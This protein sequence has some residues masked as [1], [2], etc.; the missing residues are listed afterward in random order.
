MTPEQQLIERYKE[1]IIKG[2]YPKAYYKNK[3]A[4]LTETLVKIREL[5]KLVN[6][7]L[8]EEL[9]YKPGE[10]YDFELCSDYGLKDD[11]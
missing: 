6:R 7:Q 9:L 5:E 2:E 3:E 11:K 10:R 4:W 8:R 1:I